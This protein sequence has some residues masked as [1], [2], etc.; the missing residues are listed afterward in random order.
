MIMLCVE[1]AG[2][3]LPIRNFLSLEDTDK[4]TAKSCDDNE[5]TERYSETLKSLGV[6][7]E[8]VESFAIIIQDEGTFMKIEQIMYS[9]DAEKK[10][11]NVPKI[12]EKMTDREYLLSFLTRY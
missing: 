7:S 12:F 11:A 5:L 3:Y 1:K 2:T 8:M 6:K 10:K 4:E 9:A